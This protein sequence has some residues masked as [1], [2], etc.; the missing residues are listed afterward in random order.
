V[1]FVGRGSIAGV[2][3]VGVSRVDGDEDPAFS[4]D[5]AVT[6]EDYLVI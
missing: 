3:V 2:G 4:V 5:A 1:S 6:T